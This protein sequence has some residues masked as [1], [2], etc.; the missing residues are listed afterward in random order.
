MRRN[1]IVSDKAELLKAKNDD[2]KAVIKSNLKIYKDV[3]ETMEERNIDIDKESVWFESVIQTEEDGWNT[4]GFILLNKNIL[5]FI[6]TNKEI[7]W[8]T[9]ISKITSIQNLSGSNAILIKGLSTR[10]IL[11]KQSDKLCKVL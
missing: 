3:I 11:S 2:D 8:I 5:M 4:D 10:L 1:V 9:P 7:N 6:D